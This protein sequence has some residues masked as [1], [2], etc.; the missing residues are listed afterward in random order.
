MHHYWMLA[1]RAL[2]YLLRDP[3]LG[4]NI[5]RTEII[6]EFMEERSPCNRW[7]SMCEEEPELFYATMIANATHYRDA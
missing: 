7:G 4:R 1:N 5:V 2:E 3:D 6:S